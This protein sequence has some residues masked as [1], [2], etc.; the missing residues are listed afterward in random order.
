MGE[1]Q[2]PKHKPLIDLDDPADLGDHSAAPDT[3]R[4]SWDAQ[5]MAEQIETAKERATLPPAPA[6]EMLRDSCRQLAVAEGADE[7]LDEEPPP[8]RYPSTSRVHAKDSDAAKAARAAVAA[9]ANRKK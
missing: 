5:A 1:K 4:P 9:A 3:K 8:E 7:L 6:Y 2:H